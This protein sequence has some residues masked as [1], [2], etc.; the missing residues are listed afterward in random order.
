MQLRAVHAAAQGALL[1]IS[2]TAVAGNR[3]APLHDTGPHLAYNT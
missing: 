2:S 1:M 3:A